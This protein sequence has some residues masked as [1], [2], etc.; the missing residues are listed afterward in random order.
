MFSFWA[1][2]PPV[3]HGLLICEVFRSHTTMHYSRQYSSGRVISPTRRPLSDN[4]QNSQQTHLHASGGIRTHNL[5]RR[6]V[7]DLRLRPC[8]HWDRH[9]FEHSSFYIS[10]YVNY[11]H[12][13]WKNCQVKEHHAGN[14][15]RFGRLMGTAQ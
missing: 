7:V 6:L 3:G 9:F 4:T 12:F 1:R 13:I 14:V 2:Q 8:D 5:S 11:S 10:L 15:R